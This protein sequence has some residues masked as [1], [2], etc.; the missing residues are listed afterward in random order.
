MRMESTLSLKNFAKSS[1]VQ[2]LSS[3]RPPGFSPMIP[4]I[5]CQSFFVLPL[6]SAILVRQC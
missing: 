6:L 2:S 5:V 4:R 3:H 1:A